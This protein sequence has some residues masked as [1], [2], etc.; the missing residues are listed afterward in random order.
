MYEKTIA[1][2][3]RR[4]SARCLGLRSKSFGG[5]PPML[6]DASDR[7]RMQYLLWMCCRV[8]EFDD[9]IKATSWIGWMSREAEVLG[10]V[11][12]NDTTRDIRRQDIPAVREAAKRYFTEP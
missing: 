9:P 11:E 7:D 12:N 5:K 4:V 2:L 10:L 3:R 1:D 6:S 8:L